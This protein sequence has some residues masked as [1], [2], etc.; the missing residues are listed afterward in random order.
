MEFVADKPV[1]RPRI[2][3]RKTNGHR[4]VDAPEVQSR[5]AKSAITNGSVLIPGIDQRSAWIRRCKDLIAA[6]SGDLGGEANCSTAEQSLIRRVAV[7]TTE[8]ERLEL[9]FASVGEAKPSDL[10]LYQK[11]ANTLR[12][13]VGVLGIKR[14]PKDVLTLDQYLTSQR[15]A[16]E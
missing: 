6:H 14:R 2:E 3:G 12:R 9:K 4:A 11:L 1:G 7:L 5:K 13:L 15:E 8:L 10:D 16:A